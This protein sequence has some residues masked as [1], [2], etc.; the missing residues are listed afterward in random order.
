[1]IP[2]SV[3]YEPTTIR[4]R[5]NDLFLVYRNQGNPSVCDFMLPFEDDAFVV[6]D[7]VVVGVCG[8]VF[9]ES[10]GCYGD[11]GVNIEEVVMNYTQYLEKR[12]AATRIQRAW[13]RFKAAQVIKRAW[14]SWL[15]K[16]NE[17]WNPHCFVG[18]AFLALEAI[19]ATK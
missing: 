4:F 13:K 3:S 15:T 12:T 6:E 18:V 1:M 9:S 5:L 8:Q 2:P 10:Y 16:K 11:Y 19:R 14:K 7:G 17:L